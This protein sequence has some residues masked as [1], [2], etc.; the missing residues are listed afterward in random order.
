MPIARLPVRAQTR[1]HPRQSLGSKIGHA[2]VRQKEEARI[3]D[4]QRQ[5]PP[6]LLIT[7][8]DPLVARAQPP[9]RR[10]ENQ[11]PQPVPV[12]IAHHVMQPFPHRPQ[13]AQ[14]VMLL[15]QPMAAGQLIALKQADGNGIQKQL[16]VTGGSCR[17]SAHLQ[18]MKSSGTV[19]QPRS[20]RSENG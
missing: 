3:A 12:D 14:I 1:E 8:T 17:R 4:H 2:L 16:L 9:R 10:A 20:L 6:A 18:T 19:V 11:H 5:T 15:E 13:I 7:P